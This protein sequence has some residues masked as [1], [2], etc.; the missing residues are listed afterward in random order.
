MIIYEAFFEPACD[1]SPPAVRMI[2]MQVWEDDGAR[3]VENI[4]EM[5]YSPRVGRYLAHGWL[6]VYSDSEFRFRQSDL[7]A[8]AHRIGRRTKRESV[9]EALVQH[10]MEIRL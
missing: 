3:C 4:I 1:S 9:A 5:D 7:R 6:S 2:V 10:A 8:A